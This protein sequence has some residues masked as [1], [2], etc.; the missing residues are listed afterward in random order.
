MISID[1]QCNMIAD[2]LKSGKSITALEALRKF[3]CMRLAS[4]IHDL[5]ER[6]MNIVGDMVYDTDDEGNMKKWKVYWL[7]GGN[8]KQ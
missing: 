1:T 8:D 4:R 7:E 3:G 6:G 2:Y 5:K